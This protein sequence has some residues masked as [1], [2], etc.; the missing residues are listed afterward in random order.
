MNDIYFIS[1]DITNDKLRSKIE[2]TLKNYGFRIQYS[3]FQFVV[4]SEQIIKVSDSLKNIVN[5][6]NRFVTES[7]S[8]IIIGG[9]KI[10][11]INYIIGEEQ[12]L[13]RY[14]IY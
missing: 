1:Y 7:D 3:I 11:K 14:L 12:N 2:K 5:L 9:I 13:A 8:I 10:E 4:T 6:H